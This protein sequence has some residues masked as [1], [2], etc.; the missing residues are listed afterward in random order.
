M[1]KLIFLLP[2]LSYF[3]FSDAQTREKVK[4]NNIIIEHYLKDNKKDKSI[5]GLIDVN[6]LE[7]NHFLG[8]GL[9]FSDAQGNEIDS[10]DV[11]HPF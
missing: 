4:I 11:N 5:D 8:F 9:Q 7:Q 2:L 10:Y 1:K 6:T 3:H